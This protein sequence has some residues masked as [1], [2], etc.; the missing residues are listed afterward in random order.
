MKKD[1]I[2]I[3]VIRAAIVAGFLILWEIA[4]VNN[5]VSIYYTSKPSEIILDLINFTTSGELMKHASITLKEALTGLFY[6]SIIGISAGLIFGQFSTIGKIFTPIIT[7]I[8]GIPQLTLAPVYILWFGIGFASKVFLAGLM[9]FFSVFFSTYN[10]ILT[11][12]QNLIESAS[13]LGAKKYQILLHVVLP[14]CTP[15]IIAGVRTGLG[16]S[17]VGAI[18]GEYMGAS[19]G[20]GWMVAYATSY[21]NIKRVMSCI[22]ILLLV[23]IVMN[24]GLDRIE[25]ILLRWRTQ[26]SLSIETK[27]ESKC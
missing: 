5:W 12:E 7:A 1:K 27:N 4:A 14:T 25:K 15:W 20:F 8:H 23:G 10:A 24:A 18:V 11:M 26:T 3:N 16:A 6:G 21:F 17:L 9:T 13:L 19:A 2:F 22:V